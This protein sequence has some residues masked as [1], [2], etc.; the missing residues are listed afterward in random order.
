MMHRSMMHKS[1][2]H[3]VS[4]AT[5]PARAGDRASEFADRLRA[6]ATARH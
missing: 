2:D 3:A 6:A 5:A 4:S 1:P